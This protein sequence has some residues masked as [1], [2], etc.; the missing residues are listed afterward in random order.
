MTDYSDNWVDAN[1]HNWTVHLQP[2]RVGLESDG[3]VIDIPARDYGRDIYVS[4]HAGRFIVRFATNEVEVGFVLDEATVQPFLEHIGF[5][6]NPVREVVVEERSTKSSQELLWPKVSPLAVWALFISALSFVPTAGFIPAVVACVL[7][8]LHR[9]RVRPSR[10]YSHSRN[11][12]RGAA[13]FLLLGMT[14]QCLFYLGLQVPVHSRE[15]LS[16]S[17]VSHIGTVEEQAGSLELADS[18]APLMLPAT[19]SPAA[20]D[21]GNRNWGLIIATL[22]VVV[23]SLSVHECAHAITAWWL[24]DDFALRLNRVTLNPLSHIDPLGTIVLPMILFLSGSGIFGWARPV[25]VRVANCPRPRRANILISSAGPGS[26]MLLA[27]ACLAWLICIGNAVPLAFRDAVLTGI[28]DTNIT[29]SVTA[30]G[31]PLA[32]VVAGLCT[33]LKVGFFVNVFLAFFNLIPIPPL[34]GSWVLENL[35]PFTLGPF[36]EKIRPYGF[37]IFLGLMYSDILHYLLFPA[38]IA[39][40]LGFGLVYQA[41]PLG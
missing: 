17:E 2:G 36:Y 23:M 31:F 33:I 24:G 27:A 39:I 22:F 25:P 13:A 21:L 26:N 16:A 40:G 34:D 4:P 6:Q 18:V 5:M 10:A 28:S 38:I 12:C 15:V 7:L 35:F 30:S 32:G 14:T 19:S 1:R 41:T 20:F 37:I 3:T 8:V 9:M 29:A 11:V